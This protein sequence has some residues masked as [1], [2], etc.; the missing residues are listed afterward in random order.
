[1][2]ESPMARCDGST[3]SITV[4]CIRGA[5]AR[6]EPL[7]SARFREPTRR[8]VRDR[9]RVGAGPTMRLDPAHH[10]AESDLVLRAASVALALV[11]GCNWIG[12]PSTVRVAGDGGSSDAL[13]GPAGP[14][15]CLQSGFCFETIQP[16]LTVSSVL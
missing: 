13:D 11:C 14:P 2:F 9:P 4:S 8:A 6:R 1:M 7:A 10:P 16:A 12:A 3:V 5:I 15:M